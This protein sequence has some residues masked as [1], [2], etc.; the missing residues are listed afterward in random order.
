[1]GLPEPNENDD[2][3]AAVLSLCESIKVEPAILPTDIAVSHRFGKSDSGQP[4]Q[5]LVKFDMRN[6][7]EPKRT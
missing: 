6:V 1:M 7:R 5:V 4:R 2:T 3:D